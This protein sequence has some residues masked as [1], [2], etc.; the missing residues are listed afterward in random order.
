MAQNIGDFCYRV[1]LQQ[2]TVSSDAVGG[3]IETWK[4]IDTVW[5]AEADSTAREQFMAQAPGYHLT[6][7]VRIRFRS[8]VNESWQVICHDG[9]IGRIGSLSLVGRREAI[10]LLCE[11]VNQ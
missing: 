2:K 5:A 8:D 7:V 3:V 1:Q 6:R 4:T 10:D 9:R 11:V